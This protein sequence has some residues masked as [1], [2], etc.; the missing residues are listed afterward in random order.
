MEE[1]FQNK[2]NWTYLDREYYYFLSN[3]SCLTVMKLPYTARCRMS[4][5]VTDCRAIINYFNYFEMMYC[6]FHISHKLAEIG[7]MLLFLLIV[8]L[9]LV[10]M[11]YTVN[12][13]FSPA[14]KILSIKMHMN[15]YLAGV[16]LLAFGNSAPDMISNLLPIRAEAPIFTIA[17]SNAIAIILLSG[18]MVCFVK[19]FK[20]SGPSTVR[21]LLFLFLGVQVLRYI[22]FHGNHVSFAESIGLLSIYVAYL[23]I[24]ILDLILM[25]HTMRK[26]RSEINILKSEPS[27][28]QRNYELSRKM[29]RLV[30]LEDDDNV[31]IKDSA[32]SEL[33][34]SS[35]VGN[36]RSFGFAT[37][38]PRPR[39][40][41]VDFNVTRV[42]LHNPSNPKNLFLISEFLESFIPISEED[43]ELGGW[44]RRTFL[45]VRSPL[46]IFV[47]I[48]V[49]V[50][51]YEKD[52][53]GWSK[54]LNCTQIITNPIFVITL[55]HTMLAS[56][57]TTWHINLNFSISVWSLCVTVPLALAVFIHSRTDKPPG[58][59]L[60]FITLSLSS[61]MLLITICASE[62]EVLT[63][64]LGIVFDL[65]GNFM[66]ISF[67]SIANATADLITNSSLAMQG[68]EKMA[69]AAI[70]GGPVFSIVVGM[71]VAF[72][73]NPMVRQT[74]SSFWLYGEHG[75]NCYIFLSLAILTTL[76]W[77]LTFNF[78]ARRSAAIYSW[79]LFV[80]FIVFSAGVEWDVV[81]EFSDDQFFTPI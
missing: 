34:G 66:A 26:L 36:S 67:G 68:Y 49:P 81:H 47:T 14:L 54:L 21:D 58:Y 8:V 64:I 76:W 33:R 41:P 51:D 46:V 2:A 29:Q 9:F 4:Q 13:L 23:I 10:L 74:G 52:K 17:I 28:Q 18:G 78:F 6:T 77:C 44:F 7:V 39:P 16:T 12:T 20:M 22:V 37:P 53:H 72:L 70:I 56:S 1:T 48:F 27:S 55:V 71:G 61:S 31:L 59:H 38:R 24:N 57:Y 60:L 73:F 75:G 50:V 32:G 42:I 62:I 69:F 79:V 15:E 65:S 3:M 5:Q 40:A 19:P 11:S 63:T 35:Q 25:R 43:W 80:L 45:I 30:T